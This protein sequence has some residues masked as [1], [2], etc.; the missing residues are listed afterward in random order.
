MVSNPDLWLR[1]KAHDFD[2]PEAVFTFTDRLAAEQ[3]WTHGFARRVIEEY[4]RFVYLACTSDH[5][6][7][8][9]REVDA[10][11]HLHLT[12]TRD[13]WDRFCA[14]ALRQPLHHSPP[15]DGEAEEQRLRDEYGT[16]LA[17]Y[18][19]EF[20]E[21]PD[22]EIW[23]PQDVR[24]APWEADPGGRPGRSGRLADYVAILRRAH[25]VVK[26]V[27][28]GLVALS[29]MLATIALSG[30]SASALIVALLGAAGGFLAFGLL[31]GSS[32]GGGERKR[33]ETPADKSGNWSAR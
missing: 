24:F 22:T 1:I 12:D 31:S 13:Y 4:R 27:L 26:S 30:G 28:V 21:Q 6:V 15:R 33:R 18:R 11:W 20:A 3:G 2:E 32:K 19:S 8:P 16:T 9:S 10:A 29:T 25:P 17:L 23:P 7:T 5:E 14:E